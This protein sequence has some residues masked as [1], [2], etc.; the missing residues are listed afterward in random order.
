MRCCRQR[1]CA[2]CIMSIFFFIALLLQ[3]CLEFSFAELNYAE[4]SRQTHVWVSPQNIFHPIIFI[5][6]TQEIVWNSLM[7]I[8]TIILF[9]N[10][11]QLLF[12]IFSL[13]FWQFS[14]TAVSLTVKVLQSAHIRY[15]NTLSCG[16]L[17]PNTW[18]AHHRHSA[19]CCP[20]TPPPPPTPSHPEGFHSLSSPSAR[21]LKVAL[22]VGDGELAV[23]DGVHRFTLLHPAV[24]SGL[25]LRLALG[26][27]QVG[28]D[29]VP[30]TVA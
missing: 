19:L 23:G 25:R 20:P 29:A 30:H 6:Y 28:G 5:R 3:S 10:V 9:S 4:I 22:V 8:F 24:G 21:P 26:E 27:G 18:A 11:H 13:S 14:P 2:F 7:L 12:A 17:D 15:C 1:K 16:R